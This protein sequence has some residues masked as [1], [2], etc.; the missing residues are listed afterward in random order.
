LLVV[1]EIPFDAS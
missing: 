1:F